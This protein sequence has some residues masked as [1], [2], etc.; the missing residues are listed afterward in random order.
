MEQRSAV[1]EKPNVVLLAED[2]DELRELVSTE[3]EREGFSVVS[4][5]NGSEAVSQ[6]RSLNPD[7]VLMDL[8]MPVMNGIQATKLIKDDPA[9]RHIPIIVGT[10]IDEK[11]DVVKGFEAG[12]IAYVT[13]PYFMPELKARINSVLQSKKLYDK[14]LKSEGKYRLLVENANEAIVVIQ[15][16]MLRFFNPNAVELI[17]H[18]ENALTTEPFV[19][20]V[21]PDDREE[22]LEYHTRVMVGTR[23]SSAHSF[24]VVSKNDNTTWVEAKGVCINWEDKPATLDFITDITAR[25]RAEEEM[26]YLAFYDCLTG[27]PNRL[28]FNE[29]LNQALAYAKRNKSLLATLFLDLDHFKRIN[30]TFGHHVGD[31]LLRA[32]GERLIRIIR[33]SDILARNIEDISNTNVARFGGD[34]FVL[35]L[36]N[37]EQTKDAA[38]V[39]RRILY[40][41]SDA[42][43]V[44][45]Q[46][47]F[48]TTSIGVSLYPSDGKDAETLIK[49]A[50]KAMYHA[51]NLGRNNFQ[52]YADSMKGASSERIT[53]KSDLHKALENDELLLYYQP[54]LDISTEK[55]IGT[56]AL[57]RWQHPK[58]GVVPPAEI[59][60]LAEESALIEPISEWVLRTACLQNIAWQAAGQ[61]PMRIAVNL[62]SL[63]LKKGTLVELL[64]QILNETG[65][66]P[67]QLEIELPENTLIQ[68]DGDVIEALQHLKEMGI[69]V[70]IDDFGTGYSSL[71]HLKNHPLDALKIDR[72]FIKDIPADKDSTA[73][74][75]ATI[76]MAHSLQL[77]VVAVGVETEEQLEFL[78][79]RDCDVMQ[80]Y[81]FSP[82]VPF[83]DII[84]LL[85]GE[86]LEMNL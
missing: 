46:E 70:T 36:T 19:E 59:I 34:E 81:Y 44:D 35:L 49:K 40:T 82:P 17:G 77:E 11:E 69:R 14:L 67:F 7:I 20:F 71:Y 74:V 66:A 13:K 57:I 31:L 48:I 2:D 9:T 52:F 43:M 56:E 78:R 41:L 18:P 50:D 29:H 3:L 8:M 27:L 10:V 75:T 85:Q 4:V 73:I 80:G 12:A 83:Y 26:R 42:F 76:A 16:G 45:K 53:L 51:K 68:N 54:Q 39:A 22:V 47:L 72:S 64:S 15:D 23:A 79:E 86:E 58:W 24:R 6:T 60:P 84:P 1:N 30:D 37:I 21:H 33:K 25:K 28:M 55:V 65:M 38:K 63:L 5:P 62:S 32:V 61:E